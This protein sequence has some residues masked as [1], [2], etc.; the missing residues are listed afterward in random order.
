M[1]VHGLGG[2]AESWLT[3]LDA[4]ADQL[5]LYALDLVGF[6]YSDKPDLGYRIEDFVVCIRS[7][8]EAL[9]L[10]SFALVGFSLG[11]QIAATFAAAYP[12]RVRRLVLIASAGIST[13]YT[14]ALRQYTHFAP[15]RAGTRKR[16]EALVANPR[17]ITEE[18]VDYAHMV[19]QLPGAERTF[20]KA[21]T[22]SGRAPRLT[23]LLPRIT[24]PTLILW[25]QDDPI[26]PV[27]YAHLFRAGI[28]HS[29]VQIFEHCGHVPYRE[30]PAS[31]LAA[32]GAFLRG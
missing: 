24:C 3:T 31:F 11:G 12:E 28:P 2:S 5:H 22:A 18:L 14:A 1:L 32:L 16:L 15:T 26:I 30:Q 8:G 20:R 7:F 29:Q 6:G 13:E 19:A 9:D 10:R 25:G 4:L 21:L 23:N 27:E 17:V